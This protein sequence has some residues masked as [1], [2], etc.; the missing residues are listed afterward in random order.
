[1]REIRTQEVITNQ[2]ST[3]KTE[4]TF[5]YNISVDKIYLNINYIT[6]AIVRI[7]VKIK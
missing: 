7:D 2:L 5:F 3:R 4:D 6:K 1:M